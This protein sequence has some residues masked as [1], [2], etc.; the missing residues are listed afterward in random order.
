MF[1]VMYDVLSEFCMV[2]LSILGFRDYP[3]YH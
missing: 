3:S 2:P 1:V